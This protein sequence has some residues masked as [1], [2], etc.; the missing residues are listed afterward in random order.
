MSLVLASVAGWSVAL[1]ALALALAWQRRLSQRMELVAR[2]CHEVRGPLTAVR[3]GL[4]LLDR[5]DEVAR[6]RLAAVQAELG[7]A[8][9]AL[10]DLSAA[11]WGA[12]AAD[13]LE[14]VPLDD[15][16]EEAA[17]AWRPV[18]ASRGVELTLL[19]PVDTAPAT[20]PGDRV[21]LAQACGN[22]LANAI[23]H[24][25]GAVEL[26]RRRVG[27]RVRVEV[28]D[29]GPGL[30]AP[31]AVLTRRARGG[32]GRRGRGLAIAAEI[33][34]RHGGRLQSAPSR[35]GARLALDLPAASAQP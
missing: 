4:H 3:L 30:P 20:V 32:R 23:E 31:V 35:E 28:S 25:G 26:R 18:A 9:L 34:A 5:G 14:P 2:A 19:P 12:R 29:A 11:R 33:A 13:R 10:E 27:A 22:L 7:R 24:G 8:G 16:L 15:V 1:C 6:R 21:R 17:E